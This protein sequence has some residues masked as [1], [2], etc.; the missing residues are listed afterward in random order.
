M[1]EDEFGMNLYIVNNFFVNS[2]I[3]K[4]L[5]SLDICMIVDD[6]YGCW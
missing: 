6:K 4:V 5:L 1:L 3:C 2:C